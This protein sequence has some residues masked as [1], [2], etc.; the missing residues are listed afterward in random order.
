MKIQLFDRGLPPGKKLF[1]DLDSLCQRF[2]IDDP[3]YVRDMNKVYARGL[4]GNTI[5]LIDNEVVLLISI[6][7]NQ[8]WKPF[9]Q[10]ILNKR[11]IV[12]NYFSV[13]LNSS[14]HISATFIN[15]FIKAGLFSSPRWGIGAKKGESVSKTNL[16]LGIFLTTS[17]R[18]CS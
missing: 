9:F 7:L 12:I 14:P 6:L 1:A 8:N 15:I 10:T 18:P 17:T 16:S 3:E 2:Q 11:G 5:L 13:F 4:Q